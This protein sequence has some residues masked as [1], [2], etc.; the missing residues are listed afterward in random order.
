MAIVP[1]NKKYVELENVRVSYSSKD[2]SVHLTAND[3]DMK[4]KGGLHIPLYGGSAVEAKLRQLLVDKELIDYNE[5]A[6]VL[7]SPE[8]LKMKIGDS[9]RH[10]RVHWD[11]RQSFNPMVV[12]GGVPHGSISVVSSLV[13]HALAHQDFFEI[14]AVDL[15]GIE[16]RKRNTGVAEGRAER[17]LTDN[18][19]PADFS[20]TMPTVV[21]ELSGFGAELEKLHEL[22]EAREKEINEKGLYGFRKMKNYGN[23]A[24]HKILL[25]NEWED[26]R[27]FLRGRGRESVLAAKHLSKLLS[28]GDIFGIHVF[29]HTDGKKDTVEDI[30]EFIAKLSTSDNVGHNMTWVCSNPSDFDTISAMTSEETAR[31]NRTGNFDRSKVFVA[32]GMLF[33]GVVSSRYV[34]NEDHLELVMDSKGK[35]EPEMYKQYLQMRKVTK[36]RR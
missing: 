20:V 29:I 27:H 14:V 2:D 23:G 24:K 19:N 22:M 7:F 30:Q 16:F 31:G 32:K 25:I 34:R 5:D 9:P 21:H 28:Y 11:L 6:A 3:P 12:A 26:I 15:T 4:D 17:G 10:G 13:H 33:S 8:P 35:I 1:R 18:P 36:K